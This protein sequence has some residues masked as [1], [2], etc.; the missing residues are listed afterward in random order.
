MLDADARTRLLDGIK[1]S[2]VEFL[3][4][5]LPHIEVRLPSVDFFFSPHKCTAVANHFIAPS[6]KWLIS[7]NRMV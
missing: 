3:L 5:Y 7:I 1:N 6:K 2:T 4:E